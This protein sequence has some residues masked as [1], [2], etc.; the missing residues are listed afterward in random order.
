MKYI[1]A[2]GCA[3]MIY[4]PHLAEK[5]KTVIEGIY[6]PMDTLLS[7]CFNL[8]ELEEGTCIITPCTTCNNRYRTLYKDCTSSYFLATLAESETFP[9][10]D[11]HGIS[12]SI[13]D[14]CS[15]RTDELYLNAI[16]KLL[17]RMNINIVEAE[18]SGKRG[19]CCGSVLY[20]KS[21]I[22]KVEAYM[23]KRAQEMPEEDVVVYCASCIQG[24]S[25]GNK[26]ARFI[27]DLLF[28]E[29]TSADPS[30]IVSWH[31]RLGEFQKNGCCY[32]NPNR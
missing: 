1:Y 7:C 19:K 27:I 29:P 25:L 31:N 3:L 2:P 21:P 22:E 30:G 15:G 18:K 13:Q 17:K 6:G 28:D 24:I 12:M 16:R 32:K 14:T 4:K 11:Y 23:K 10:P 5:L 20:G 26:R 8:P 9:F